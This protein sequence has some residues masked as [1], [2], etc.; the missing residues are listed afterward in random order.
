MKNVI[1]L[2]GENTSVVISAMPNGRY[3]VAH[4]Y[5]KDGKVMQ[6][7]TSESREDVQFLIDEAMA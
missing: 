3:K 7:V 5:K 1:R 2:L 6:F 4:H